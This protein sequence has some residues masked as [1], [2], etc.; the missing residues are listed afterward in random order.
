MRERERER[1]REGG[2]ENMSEG[3][4]QKERE[5]QTP[6][7]VRSPMTWVPFQDAGITT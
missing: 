2:R 1:I 6:H 5:K 3:R 7:G 4:R